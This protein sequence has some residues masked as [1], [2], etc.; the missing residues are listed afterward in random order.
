MDAATRLLR[1]HLKV[2]QVGFADVEADQQHI[3]VNRDSND[4]QIP[5][6]VGRWHMDDFG[7]ALV[8]DMKRGQSNR[9]L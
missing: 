7:P 5:S 8:A 2:A 1:D 6:V 3:V 9:H 4:G